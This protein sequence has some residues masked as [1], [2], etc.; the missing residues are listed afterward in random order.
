MSSSSVR[1][2]A[3][4]FV[5]LMASLA[6]LAT[7]V[8]AHSAILLDVDTHHVVLDPGQSSNITLSIENNGSSIESYE[9]TVD[10][11]TLNSVWTVN[12]TDAVVDNVFPTWTRNTTLVIQ[13]STGAVPADSGSFNVHVTEPDQDIT[14]ILTVFVSVAPSYSPLIGFETMGSSLVMLEAGAT[15]DYTVDVTNDGSVEDTFLLDAEFEPDLV[16]WWA[17]QQSNNTGGNNTGGNGSAGNNTGGNNTGGNNTGGNGTAGNNTG[18]NSSMNV[19][20]LSN[21]MMYGNSYTSFNSLNGL[22]ESMGVQNA[23]AITPGGHRLDEHWDDVNTSG[24]IANTTLRDP[25]IDW[26]YVVLQDQSQV[27]GF[28]RTSSNWIASKDGAVNLAQAVDDEGSESI[29]FMTWGRR[30]GDAMNPTLYSN[31]TIMQERLEAGYIDYHANMTATGATVW[32]A[33]V[34]LAFQHIHDAVVA[35]GINAST[36]GNLF[37]DLYNPDGSHPSLAGSYLA[38]CV[39]HATMNGTSPVGSND[40]V[41]LNATIKLQLQQ[42]AAATVFNETSHIEYPWSSSIAATTSSRGLGGGIPTGWNIQWLDDQLDNI[43]A[44][45]SQQATLQV[46]VPADVEP[47]YYGFRLF[48]ASTLGNVSTSTVLVVHVD[49]EHNLSMAFLDQ[50]AQFIPGATTNT[51]VRVTNTGN[52]EADFDWEVS[53]IG[54]PCQFSL[55]TSST[56]DFA[57]DAVIDLPVQVTVDSVATTSNSCDFHLTGTTPYGVGTY[58]QGATF[59]LQVDELIAFEL[60]ASVPSIEVEQGTPTAYEVHLLNNG[61]ETRTFILQVVQHADLT[62]QLTSPSELLV[63]AGDTGVWQVETSAGAGAVGAYNQSFEVTRSGVTD[64][65]SIG[66]QVLPTRV[67][68]LNGPLDGRILMQPGTQTTTNFTLV[69]TGTG[70]TSLVAFLSGLPASAVAE[71]SHTSATLDVGASLGITLSITLTNNAEPGTHSLVFGYGGSGASASQSIDLQIQDRFSVLV[72][73]AVSDVVAGPAN[74]AS[75]TFDITN[76]GTAGDTFQLSI[77]D[78]TETSWFSYSL[79]TTS[80]SVEPGASAILE[81]TV[82]ETSTGATA[83]GVQVALLA[84]SSNDNGVS[85]HLNLTVRPQI[86]G[87]EITVIADDDEAQPGSTIRGTVVVQNT[88]TGADQLLLTTVGIDCGVTTQFDLASGASSAAIP[89]SCMIDEN[90]QSGLGELKFRVTSSSRSEYVQS[91]TEIYTVEPSWE[92]G[93]VLKITTDQIGYTVPYSGGTTLVVTVENLANTRVSGVLDYNGQGSAMLIGQWS[94]YIDN[95]S[96]SSFSLAPFGTMDFELTLTSD[97][98]AKEAAELF[99]KATFTIDATST[100]ASSESDVFS[101]TI[102]G[103]AQAPQGVTLPLGFQLDGA[104]T[105]NAILGGWAFAFLLLGVMYLRRSRSDSEAEVPSETLVSEEAAEVEPEESSELGFN[106]CRM[107]AGKVSCPSCEAR[108]GVPRASAPPFRFTCPQCSTMIR[109]VE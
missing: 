103:P 75:V 53:S 20:T 6:P 39:L 33:P 5:L 82:R 12:T 59:T 65:A 78:K 104:S 69:N 74:D 28:L 73:S 47:D 24:D 94:T 79:S 72:S 68:E 60:G 105:I 44:G 13:L 8:A 90:A 97:V 62:T 100:T 98:Q 56:L 101:V 45:T 22:L 31:F 4:V 41:A 61:S 32:I 106:E 91:Y 77:V 3:F 26:D 96:S 58:T 34:G 14:S 71:I 30:N 83:N 57:P 16:A 95:E 102:K 76:L 84:T 7:P 88:G 64:V 11:G 48:A 21:V 38:A 1:A 93:S 85:H 40:T 36:S 23:D 27:P 51:T 49:E 67:I 99:I 35:G 54:G 9:V 66:V 108:L 25:N 86:A 10:T 52:A 89:W 70:N 29:L 63:A 107:E 50:D 80:L 37:Y 15:S 18:G 2:V 92:E 19:T 55:P 17:S 42:A 43:P 87:A 46:S 81:L 109:V